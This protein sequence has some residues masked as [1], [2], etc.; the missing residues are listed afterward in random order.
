MRILGTCFLDDIYS[1]AG[2]SC[3][4]TLWKGTGLT[5]VMN[6]AQLMN[7]SL[8]DVEI[9]SDLSPSNITHPVIQTVADNKA[10]VFPVQ[11]GMTP[12]RY[13]IVDFSGPIGQTGSTI[14][15]KKQTNES[16][17][18]FL[19]RTFDLYSF[20]AIIVSTMCVSFTL[21]LSQN[22]I[23][24]CIPFGVC[25]L[26]TIGNCLAQ[27]LPNLFQVGICGRQKLIL[28]IH[29]LMLVVLAK[30]FSGTILASLLS[31]N[32]PNQI[33][34]LW[35]VEKLPSL[36]IICDGGTHWYEDLMSHPATAFMKDRI[37][38]RDL[39]KANPS[40]TKK[41]LDDVFF[42]T[43]VLIGYDN[44]LSYL[45]E[46]SDKYLEDEFHKA[47]IRNKPSALALPKNATEVSKKIS[48]GTQWLVAFGLFDL[49]DNK[50]VIQNHHDKCQTKEP[51]SCP[52]NHKANRSPQVAYKRRLLALRRIKKNSAFDIKHFLM[53]I[54]ILITGLCLSSITFIIEMIT[55]RN[56]K[57]LVDRNK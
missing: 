35:D 43:H 52:R 32:K 41:A 16:I 37:E 21:W 23:T 24:K 33:E 8:S 30:S 42:G 56:T 45:L 53:I 5:F 20:V 6:L 47:Q 18:N 22:G 46:S 38:I 25:T 44:F 12:L 34:S 27:G 13:T 14:F 57:I 49:R 15:S 54:Y 26:Y 39:L 10:D 55:F 29:G 31:Q 40:T 7:I 1:V 36:R 48:L 17:G 11:A 51:R 4:T 28:V 19:T 9:V 2:D 3:N 50:E